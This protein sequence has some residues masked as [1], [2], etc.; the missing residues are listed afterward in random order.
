MKHK[1]LIVDDEPDML[2][3]CKEAVS[4]ENIIVALETDAEEALQKLRSENFDLLVTDV[5]MPKG[6]GI[7]LLKAA[8][9]SDPELPVI[10]MTAYPEVESAVAALRAGALDYF[11]K[12]FHPEDF[13]LKVRRALEEKR[14]RAENKLLVRHVGKTYLPDEIIGQSQS[15]RKVLELVD[16]VAS[17]TADVLI[18]GESGTGKE[19]IAR[20]L[21]TLSGRKGHF[22]PL[23]CGAIP[24][25]LMENELF[26]HEKGAYTDATSSTPGLLEFAH[27]G[28]FFLDEVCELPL[29]L[30]AKLLRTFQERQFRR[31]GGKEFHTVNIRIV[32]ATNKDIQ[33]EV[34]EGRFRE[35]LYYR[36]NVVAI[37]IPPLRERREDIQLLTEHYVS[38]ISREMGKN[39]TFVENE[40][41]EIFSHYSW[42][43]NVRELVNVL[44][45]A[46]IFCE[47]NVIKPSD[48]PEFLMDESISPDGGEENFYSL[49]KK[50]IQSFEKE[51]FES[52]LQKH[53][54]DAAA[55]AKAAGLPLSNFYW[56]LKKHQLKPQS[57]K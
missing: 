11:I 43:G 36:L 52:L 39:I 42:T 1:I 29:S 53:H 27:E 6:D 26:G 30:Q 3:T 19:L 46:I 56:H 49:K 40:A 16:R 21:H 38:K 35:D 22:V 2:S 5:K 12:P 32:A 23:D 44:R 15:L 45:R 54:G 13:R 25:N 28:T 24:E 14:L 18:L 33:K 51:Y 41:H 10:I 55:S 20:R 34:K 37:G 31:V 8:K 47:G 17:T 48:L 57:F 50:Q 9:T 7:D 4:D